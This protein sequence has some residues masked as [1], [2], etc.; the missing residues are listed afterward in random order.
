M[1]NNTPAPEQDSVSKRGWW[2]ALKRAK[3]EFSKDQAT[4]L[5]AALTYY[6]VLA[7]FPA[8]IGLTG[9]L[10]LV[11]RGPETTEALLDVV[12]DL[13]GSSVVDPL[14]EVLQSLQTSSGSGIAAILGLLGSV[15]SASGFVGAFGRAMN[16]IYEVPEG[17]P[18]WKLRPQMFLIT[19]LLMVMAVLIGVGLVVSGPVTEAIS[20]AL[21]L[22][23]S[24]VTVWDI[25]KWPVMAVL[26]M[27]AI[28]VLYYFTPN[29]K[30][31]KFRLLTPGAVLAFL[32]WALA[33]AGLGFY[34]SNFGSYNKTY[35]A[36][37][38]VVVFLLWIWVS[39]VMLLLGAELDAE[40]ERARE[41]QAGIAAEAH[42]RLEPRDL[43]GTEKKRAAAAQ[44]I[45]EAR[46]Y[47]IEK[48]ST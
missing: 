34:V 24:L 38:G 14:A 39:N 36:L 26:A 29:V 12:R 2:V 35:G 1:T 43:A 6:G 7:I 41:L 32:S 45:S 42:L 9:L 47:R 16:R 30:I 19:L 46:R 27:L 20:R 15:W 13:G 48:A 44:E 33:S 25:A 10:G 3:A 21:G 31:P 4:D 5:A 11:G 18:V 40:L 37:A 17:R 22:S 28:A 8:F 23:D